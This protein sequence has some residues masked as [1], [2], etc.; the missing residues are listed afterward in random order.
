MWY[1][2]G[3]ISTKNRCIIK[4]PHPRSII[5]GSIHLNISVLV[6]NSAFWNYHISHSS[7]FES[8]MPKV[9]FL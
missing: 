7:S 9:V 1:R 8:F 2:F 6:Y 4:G 5:R 3:M